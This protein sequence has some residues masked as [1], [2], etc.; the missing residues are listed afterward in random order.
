MERWNAWWW[1]PDEWRAGDEQEHVS[2][3]GGGGG[4]G[5]GN[6]AYKAADPSVCADV[7]TSHIDDFPPTRKA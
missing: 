3:Q 1:A 5:G 7:D 2:A 6:P 4:G